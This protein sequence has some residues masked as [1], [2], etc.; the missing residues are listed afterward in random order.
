M[1]MMMADCG[2]VIF[3]TPFKTIHSLNENLYTKILIS[4]YCYFHTKFIYKVFYKYCRRVKG[5]GNEDDDEE[6]MG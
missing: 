1:L 6:K 5:T 2:H 4:A 3:S